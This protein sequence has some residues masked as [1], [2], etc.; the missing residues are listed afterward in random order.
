MIEKEGARELGSSNPP[1][2]RRD[3]GHCAF[4]IFFFCGTARLAG[5]I[6]RNGFVYLKQQKSLLSSP[7][8]RSTRASVGR[9]GERGGPAHR[10][11]DGV[12][13]RQGMKGQLF[14]MINIAV[15]EI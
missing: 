2:Y 5:C 12:I 4:A 10:M 11:L 15:I 3:D 14:E 7:E 8:P 6:L 13:T 9:D 1:V